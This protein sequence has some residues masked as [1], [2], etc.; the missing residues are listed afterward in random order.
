MTSAYSPASDIIRRLTS[1]GQGGAEAVQGRRPI[2][3]GD[4]NVAEG[5]GG[6][7]SITIGLS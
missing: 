6:N 4:Q 3:L 5:A 7:R 2:A 1:V